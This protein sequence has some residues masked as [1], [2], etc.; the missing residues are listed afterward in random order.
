[1]RRT[2]RNWKR[3]TET[4]DLVEQ[5]RLAVYEGRR[6]LVDRFKHKMLMLK[7]QFLPHYSGKPPKWRLRLRTFGGPRTLPDFA[8]VGAIKGG[9][10]DLSTYLL[11]HPCILP[12]LSK[13]IFATNTSAWFPYYPTVREKA[14]VEKEYGKALSGYFNPWMHNLQIIDNYRIA[15]PDAKIILM[16]R[17]PVDRAH[18]HYK[19]DLFLGGKRQTSIP[20][21]K[22]YTDYINM[23]LDLFPA[24]PLPSRCGFPLLQ[25]G[26]YVKSVE[27][28]I[29]RFGRENVYVLRSEDFFH[30]IEST[31]YGIH[32]FLGIPPMKPEIHDVVNRNPIKLPPVEAETRRR[33]QEFYHPWNEKLYALLDRD[34]GWE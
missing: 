7:F 34:M 13:E 32:E 15:R 3:L 23:A 11:Q 1:M 14:Q 26:I 19:W 27:L 33:L 25:S 16:L 4:Y 2:V 30:D 10:S 28:W 20:Y 6:T 12:P 9:S 8:C 5:H 17:N 18:S 31:V 21:Y 24:T 29:D 22:T